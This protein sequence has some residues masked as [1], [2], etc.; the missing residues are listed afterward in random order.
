ME[1]LAIPVDELTLRSY[2]AWRREWFLLTAGDYAAGEYN[3]MTTAWGAI[4]SMWDRPLA[5]VAVKPTR[6]TF[7]FL[8]RYPTFTLCHF[9]RSF[10]K[11]LL[12]LGSKSGRDLNKIADSGLTPIASSRV[13]APGYAEADLVLECETVYSDDYKPERFKREALRDSLRSERPH[14]IFFGEILAVFGTGDYLVP[15][16]SSDAP[17]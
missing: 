10:Q 7:A 17:G 3:C 14:R 13:A 2:R 6:H 8:E 1:R 11:K 9:P 12:Y 4:G 16:R 5:A 15:S